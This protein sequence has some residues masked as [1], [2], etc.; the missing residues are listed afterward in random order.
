MQTLPAVTL[1]GTPVETTR[2]G[3]GCAGL[4]RVPREARRALLEEAYAAGIRHF[5]V[6]RSYGLG[7]AER[8]VA[9]F[10]RGRRAELV[11]TT[12]FGL[13]VSARLQHLRAVQAPLRALLRRF[14][15][16]RRLAARAAGP[17]ADTARR[18]GAEAARAS[19]AVSLR[20]L[21]TDHVD[22]F[23]LHEPTPAAL[24]GSDVLEFL[25]RARAAGQ[26]RTHGLAGALEPT[27][28]LAR[29]SPE[30]APVLQL[31]SDVLTRGI[32]RAASVPAALITFGVLAA[33]LPAILAHVRSDDRIRRRWSERLGADASSSDVVAALLLRAALR[34]NPSGVVLF[35][36]TRPERV[37]ALAAAAARPVESDPALDA[38]AELVARELRASRS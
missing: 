9:A 13:E 6:A 24:R 16:L 1:R 34:D 5:D 28:E 3:F 37:R 14:P 22:L 12:K 35:F 2:L 8:E 10:A 31:P 18:F 36:T 29:T 21:A 25:D 30:L 32:E 20:E 26:I 17:P 27:L 15:A 38:L 23:L 33:A 4:L 19:L 11:L 7:L